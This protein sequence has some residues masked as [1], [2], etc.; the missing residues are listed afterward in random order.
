MFGTGRV[1]SLLTAHRTLSVRIAAVTELATALGTLC[2][3]LRLARAALVA[4]TDLSEDRF[5]TQD[6]CE[7]HLEHCASYLSFQEGCRSSAT[8]QTPRNIAVLTA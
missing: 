6:T 4:D 3:Q 5:P 2:G 8:A 1:L 7:Q